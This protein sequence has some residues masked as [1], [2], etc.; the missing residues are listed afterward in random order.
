M[1]LLTCEYIIFTTSYSSFSRLLC[2]ISF[3]IINFLVGYYKYYL[4]VHAPYG[5]NS[6]MLHSF[7]YNKF[8]KNSLTFEFISEIYCT[9]MNK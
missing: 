3:I 5:V 4:Y 8:I 2:A 1:V 6:V 9:N 7:K